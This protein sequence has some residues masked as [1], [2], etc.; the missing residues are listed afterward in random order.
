MTPIFGKL[1]LVNCV[2]DAVKWGVYG[3]NLYL[4]GTGVTRSFSGSCAPV[5]INP[6]PTIGNSLKKQ[7]SLYKVLTPSIKP[8][9]KFLWSSWCIYALLVGK[10]LSETCP[11]SAI[12]PSTISWARPTSRSSY[13]NVW[14]P[15][16][17]LLAAP[18]SNTRGRPSQ[19]CYGVLQCNS[20]Y[21]WGETC[22]THFVTIV[23]INTLPCHLLTLILRAYIYS[24][25]AMYLELTK[26]VF[27]SY[28][29]PSNKENS[30][31]NV[32]YRAGEALIHRNNH[33]WFSFKQTAFLNSTVK[34]LQSAAI[35]SSGG[36]VPCLEPTA[37]FESPRAVFLFFAG[38]NG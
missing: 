20:T 36:L 30:P 38:S 3:T 24:C 18:P 22:R 29:T 16:E 19:P 2:R 17:G 11:V 4:N 28:Y 5:C 8:P 9:Y 35:C 27:R 32:I 7:K 37:V 33:T 1:E 15:C 23:T 26:C 14:W 34:C 13:S 12:F 6:L 31:R 25:N 10:G 21:L